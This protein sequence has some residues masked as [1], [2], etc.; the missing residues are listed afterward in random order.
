MFG[1]ST[2]HIPARGVNE[3][4]ASRGRNPLT[5]EEDPSLIYLENTK[6]GK[7]RE[8]AKKPKRQTGR[9]KKTVKCTLCGKGFARPSTLRRHEETIHADEED[10]ESDVSDDGYE[11]VV[12]KGTGAPVALE[13][14]DL[15]E[16]EGADHTE[17]SKIHRRNIMSAR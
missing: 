2:E 5:Y 8:A 14:P 17:M 10:G 11:R 6:V 15:D 1:T 4:M 12:Q 16:I 9:G 7:R 3:K 13:L